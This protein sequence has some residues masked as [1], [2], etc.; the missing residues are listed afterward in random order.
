MAVKLFWS[1]MF[2][3]ST[4]SANTNASMLLIRV[5]SSS[6]N[7]GFTETKKSNDF[8]VNTDDQTI[9]MCGGKNHPMDTSL[10]KNCLLFDFR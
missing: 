5:S 3:P 1:G 6:D 4:R 9:L 7:L 8:S 2:Y 10:V